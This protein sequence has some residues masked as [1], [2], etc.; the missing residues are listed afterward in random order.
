MQ[1]GQGLGRVT[2]RPFGDWWGGFCRNGWS[3]FSGVEEKIR[4]EK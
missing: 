4:E 3:T 1:T 2:A